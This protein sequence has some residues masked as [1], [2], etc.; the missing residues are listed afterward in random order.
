MGLGLPPY[1]LVHDDLRFRE[2]ALAHTHPLSQNHT[3][4]HADLGE[5]VKVTVD[6]DTTGA[7]I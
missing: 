3:Y 5:Q 1:L 4:P 2:S 6:A 7:T